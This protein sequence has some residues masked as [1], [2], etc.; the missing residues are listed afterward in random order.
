MRFTEAVLLVEKEMGDKQGLLQRAGGALKKGAKAVGGAVGRVAKKGYEAG[1]EEVKAGIAHVQKPGKQRKDMGKVL[2][3]HLATNV[4]KHMP[5]ELGPALKALQ[6]KAKNKQ[7]SKL[8]GVLT[9]AVSAITTAVAKSGDEK[10]AQQQEDPDDMGVLPAAEESVFT[11]QD[12]VAIEEA[13]EWA[14]LL[15]ER[16][17]WLKQEDRVAMRGLAQI[18]PK[19]HKVTSLMATLETKAKTQRV[20]EA[21]RMWQEAFMIFERISAYI[22]K[23]EL[24][25]ERDDRKKKEQGK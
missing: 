22:K 8:G 16:G 17:E 10:K 7:L 6:T 4:V 25:G 2:D 3:R 14:S 11:Y 12:Y 5:D 9:K 15:L 24:P 21:I 20:R 23:T 1:K 13:K 19:L 18:A